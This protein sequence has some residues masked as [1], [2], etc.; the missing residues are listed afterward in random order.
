[1]ILTTIPA[2]NADGD[3]DIEEV[4][5]TITDTGEAVLE[6]AD[7]IDAQLDGNPA[8]DN[9]VP[10]VRQGTGFMRLGAELL[11]I[12]G[13]ALTWK[14]KQ[15]AETLLAEVDANPQTPKAEEQATTLKAK[16]TARK[17]AG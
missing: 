5:P 14:R 8:V 16:K 1:M 10:G 9:A 4:G 17:L 15:E 2:C 6:T 11:L 7:N 3:F 13:A 12:L